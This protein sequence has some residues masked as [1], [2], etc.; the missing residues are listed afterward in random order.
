MFNEAS[1]HDRPCSEDK[2]QRQ[3]NNGRRFH[4]GAARAVV[5]VHVVVAVH[6]EQ[7]L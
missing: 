2:Q 7:D 5:E 4:A 3:L 6:V 1:S